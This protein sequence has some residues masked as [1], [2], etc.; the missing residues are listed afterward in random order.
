MEGKKSVH[1]KARISRRAF[2]AMCQIAIIPAIWPAMK[3]IECA[4]DYAIDHLQ[5]RGGFLD[6]LSDRRNVDV[7]ALVTT[8]FLRGG[9]DVDNPTVVKSL[10]YLEGAVQPD[11]GIYVPSRE[12]E[13]YESCLATV[14]F[15]M[16]NADRRYDGLL[17]N[18]KAFVKTCQWD[19]RKGKQRSDIV[20]GGAGYG[21]QRRPDLSNTAFLLDAI[22]SCRS[23]P[24]DPSVKK[25]LVF[26]SRCQNVEGTDNAASAERDGGFHYTCTVDGGSTDA[27]LVRSSGVMTMNGLKSLLLAGVARDDARVRSAVAWVRSHYDM[28]GNPGMGDAG[29]YHY[30]HACA[31]TLSILGEDEIEDAAGV[32]HNWRNEL[33][34]EIVGRQ[35]K[36]GSWLNEDGFW[37]EDDPHVA[38][39]LALLTLACCQQS[40]KNATLGSM[41]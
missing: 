32:R 14:C 33:C 8:A 10:K 1:G 9:K 25:A 17:R 12:L 13:S 35:R 7:T 22:K 37:M 23:G 28:K 36:D 11:G 29:L 39:A 24:D 4:V 27:L 6:R 2:T 34:T 18:A 31:E 21:R 16:A 15:G 20:Y 38:T 3:L 5:S 19:E 30:Y 41:T 26:V 40:P